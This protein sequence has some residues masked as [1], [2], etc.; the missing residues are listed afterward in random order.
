MDHD[1]GCIQE[2]G[3]RPISDGRPFKLSGGLTVEDTERAQL[4]AVTRAEA[5]RDERQYLVEL[6]KAVREQEEREAMIAAAWNSKP[7]TGVVN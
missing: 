3:L 6:L 5:I 2:M 4:I 7:E 1:P